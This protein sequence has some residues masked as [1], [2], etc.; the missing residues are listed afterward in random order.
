MEASRNLRFDK[1]FAVINIKMYI[2]GLFSY[3]CRFDAFELQE[4]H[5]K[6]GRQLKISLKL[7]YF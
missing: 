7:S 5:F 6:R 2:I 4:Y 3:S 1:K